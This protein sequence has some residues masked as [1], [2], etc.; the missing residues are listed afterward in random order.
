MCGVGVGTGVAMCLEINGIGIE[1]GVGDGREARGALWLTES[2]AMPLDEEGKVA[3]SSIIDAFKPGEFMF[4]EAFTVHDPTANTIRKEHE[5]I[6][7]PAS[8]V[9]HYFDEGEL[10]TWFST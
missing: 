6:S 2:L 5:T 8:F 3:A 10:A 9:Q 1:V 7:E 4:I